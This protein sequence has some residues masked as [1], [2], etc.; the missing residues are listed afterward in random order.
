MGPRTFDVTQSVAAY[1]SVSVS[2][3]TRRPTSCYIPNTVSR[4]TSS[5]EYTAVSVVTRRPTSCYTPNTVG[6]ITSSWDYTAAS[7]RYSG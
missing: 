7:I 5:W 3:V 1:Y 6:R 2:V 4:I